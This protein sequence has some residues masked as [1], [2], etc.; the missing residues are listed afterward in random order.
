MSFCMNCGGQNLV[1]ADEYKDVVVE[2]GEYEESDGSY[3]MESENTVQKCTDC[4]HELI[5]LSS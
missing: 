2:R 1:E 5:D 3:S 4:G